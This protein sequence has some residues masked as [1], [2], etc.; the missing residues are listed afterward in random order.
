MARIHCVYDA[1]SISIVSSCILFG[2]LLLFS[3]S[4]LKRPGCYFDYYL[5]FHKCMRDACVCVCM[6]ISFIQRIYESAA[7]GFH[8]LH[9]M[10]DDTIQCTIQIIITIIINDNGF[11]IR[12]CC[13]AP[14]FHGWKLVIVLMKN[15]TH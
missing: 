14:L 3:S 1:S 13:C 9:G 11:D 4:Q 10:S 12:L 7:I 6:Q 5:S 15:N 2:H 8:S